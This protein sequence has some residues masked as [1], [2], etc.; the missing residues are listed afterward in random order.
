MS[1]IVDAQCN[2]EKKRPLFVGFNYQL[3][4]TKHCALYNIQ[5]ITQLIICNVMPAFSRY[6]DL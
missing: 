5:I 2:Y 3:S 6:T 1:D 4:E